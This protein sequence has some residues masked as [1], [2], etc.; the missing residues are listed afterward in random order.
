MLLKVWISPTTRS[1]S[2]LAT[3]DGTPIQFES[4]GT[5]TRAVIAHRNAALMRRGGGELF[6]RG[7]LGDPRWYA[8]DRSLNTFNSVENHGTQCVQHIVLIDDRRCQQWS[9][10]VRLGM[11]P[12]AVK[13]SYPLD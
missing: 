3:A 7:T 9:W 2:G 1:R 8:L 5:T 6:E 11:D 12:P 4:Q 10:L 13:S